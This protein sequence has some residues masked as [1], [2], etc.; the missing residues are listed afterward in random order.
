MSVCCSVRH[1]V[2]PGPVPA[3]HGAQDVPPDGRRAP[4]AA[5]RR[6]TLHQRQEKM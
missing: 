6:A 5:A 4:P 3:R 1:G 2:P